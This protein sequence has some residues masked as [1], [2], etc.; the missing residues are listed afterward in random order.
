MCIRSRAALLGG[1]LA[2]LGGLFTGHVRAQTPRVPVAVPRTEERQQTIYRPEYV[3]EMRDVFRTVYTP[4]TTYHWEAKWRPLQSPHWVWQAVPHVTWQSKIEKTSV[5]VTSQH[6][7][8]ETKTVR[9]PYL[10]LGF[11][12]DPQASIAAAKPTGSNLAGGAPTLAPQS[13][14]SQSS[15]PPRLATQ[16]LATQRLATPHTAAAPTRSFANTNPVVGAP[17]TSA[18]AADTPSLRLGGILRMDSD[19]PRRGRLV[20]DAVMFR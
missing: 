5:P 13:S 14:A 20:N 16:Q 8:A 18:P 12:P 4:V 9:T 3:T 15:P 10:A 2:I 11:K 6:Y 17:A 7:V 1:A 19:P